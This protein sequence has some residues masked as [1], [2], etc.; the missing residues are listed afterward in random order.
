MWLLL[1][2]RFSLQGIVFSTSKLSQQ[3]ILYSKRCSPVK[4]VTSRLDYMGLHR[5]SAWKPT[6]GTECRSSVTTR[7][8]HIRFML[9]PLHWQL[10]GSVQG[11]QSPTKL[12]MT[13]DS[14]TYRASSPTLLCYDSFTYLIKAVSGCCPANG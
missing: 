8:L 11:W 7:S 14:H 3:D 2:C 9:Q 6:A 12:L 5:K 10:P 1:L 4:L 13:L